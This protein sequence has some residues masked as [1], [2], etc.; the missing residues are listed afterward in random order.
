[1]STLG[2]LMRFKS[3][4][5]TLPRVLACLQRQTRQPDLIVGVDNG[6]RDGSRALLARAGARFVEWPGQ[7][8]AAAVLN[9]GIRAC[10]TDLVLILSAHT[11]LD[12]PDAL[13]RYEAAFADPEICAASHRCAS[14]SGLYSDRVD[15]AEVQA[16]GMSR[17]SLFSASS[18]VLRRRHWEE[19][20]FDERIT[21]A[22]EDYDWILGQLARGRALAIVDQPRQYL[23][24]PEARRGLRTSRMVHAIAS[25]HGLRMRQGALRDVADIARAAWWTA[26][27][28]GLEGA[29]RSQLLWELDWA[30]GRYSWRKLDP[31]V[32]PAAAP[33][34]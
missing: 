3:S 14:F 11:L 13:R 31:F 10:T 1:M 20:P 30:W 16:K 25:R 15:L 6:S 32:Q 23:R 2:I 19:L 29:A 5:R 34:P 7:Y 26:K 4:A 33:Q 9:A 28:A 22:A 8:H 24:R 12:D 21:R 18:G 17:A 27:T